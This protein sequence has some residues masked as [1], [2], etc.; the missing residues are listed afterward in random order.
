MNVPSLAGFYGV[1][2]KYCTLKGTST[3]IKCSSR[4]FEQGKQVVEKIQVEYPLVDGSGMPTYYFNRSP[5][6]EYVIAFIERVKALANHDEANGFLNDFAVLQSLIDRSSFE[7][8][9]TIVFIFE[10][11][12]IGQGPFHRVY[13]LVNED[14]LC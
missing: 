9:L 14:D 8:L 1:T 6:C 13:R 11:G 10:V 4:L 7:A 12:E 3:S 2:S 5:L